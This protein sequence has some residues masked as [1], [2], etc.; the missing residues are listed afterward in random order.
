MTDDD[1]IEAVAKMMPGSA[2]RSYDFRD[3]ASRI[4]ERVRAHNCSGRAG[5]SAP[6]TVR[7]YFDEYDGDTVIYDGEPYTASSE[8]EKYIHADIAEARI[9]A[10]HAA[11]VRQGQGEA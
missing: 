6:E 9:A 7:I 1:L 5:T 10:A 3:A 2:G 4:I 11:G 8:Y